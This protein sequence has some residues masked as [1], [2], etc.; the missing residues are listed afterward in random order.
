MGKH[1]VYAMVAGTLLAAAAPATAT[2]VFLDTFSYTLNGIT[3][4]DTFSDG[5][6][7]PSGPSGPSTYTVLGTVQESGGRVR[8][9]SVGTALVPATGGG[10][11]A[12][13][14]VQLGGFP[15]RKINAT[16]TDTF[17]ITGIFDLVVPDINGERYGV[18]LRDE[19]QP[20]RSLIE[21]SVRRDLDGPRILFRNSNQAPPGVISE[22]GSAVLDPAHAQ[23]GLTLTH[24]N[25]TDFNVNASYF[26]I[27]VDGGVAGPIALPGTSTT[28][29][30]ADDAGTTAQLFFSSLIPAAVPEPGTMLLTLL[31]LGLIGLR[32]RRT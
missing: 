25:A 9:D 29:L 6:A 19:T 26:Y 11:S 27:D 18:R 8:L 1:S 2:V 3:T 21:V 14:L 32:R 17:S 12:T 22:F 24:A 30:F 13:E 10:F 7:P 4:T 15:F 5:A 28:N 20:L 31:G 23:I 16:T